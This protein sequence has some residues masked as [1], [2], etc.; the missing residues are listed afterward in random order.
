MTQEQFNWL[1]NKAKELMHKT[2]DPVHDWAHIE[3]VLANMER[4][5]K[6]L[7]VDKI[8]KLDDKIL[9][10][11]VAWHDISYIQHKDTFIQYIVESWRS[12]KLINQYFKQMNL[13]KKEIDLVSD[14]VLH[15]DWVEL[16][17]LRWI[18]LNKRRS[19]YHQ[20]VQDA[21][22]MDSFSDIRVERAEENINQSLF[23][24]IVMKILKPLFFNFLVKHKSLVYNLPE[25]INRLDKKPGG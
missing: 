21:D 14:I 5:N 6:L 18:V 19:I 13:S 1:F 24:R 15:H 16:V 4:I 12:K 22:T 23:K 9:K 20:I 25:I 2:L 3:R 7:P 10:L 11:A 8:K 17:F